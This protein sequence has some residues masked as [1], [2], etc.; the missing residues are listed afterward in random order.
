MHIFK[1]RISFLFALVFTNFV[2]VSEAALSSSESLKPVNIQTSQQSEEESQSLIVDYWSGSYPNIDLTNIQIAGVELEPKMSEEFSGTTAL[3]ILMDTSNPARQ[4][5]VAQNIKDSGL[6]KQNGK[7]TQSIA[8]A[9]FDK[10]LSVVADFETDDEAWNEALDAVNAKGMTTELWRNVLEG[11]NI[12]DKQQAERKALII[13]T[14]GKAEDTAYSLDEVVKRARE[15]NI[16]V[17]GIG[18]PGKV[19]E[20]VFLQGLR[21]VS[22]ETGGLFTEVASQSSLTEEKAEQIVSAINSG[23]RAIFDLQALEAENYNANQAATYNF[24]TSA[25]GENFT[26]SEDIDLSAFAAPDR[27]Q[28][29]YAEKAPEPLRPF[30]NSSTVL[31]GAIL[32]GLLMV[33]IFLLMLK[34]QREEQGQSGTAGGKPIAYLRVMDSSDQPIS[35]TEKATRLGRNKDNDVVL[36]NDSVSGFHAEIHLRREGHLVIT[37]MNSMNGTLLN[38]EKIQSAEVSANDVISVGEVKLM[39]LKA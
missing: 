3:L 32:L 28:Q 37:D 20:T 22:D 31:V 27:I 13:M 25:E 10:E 36:D 15:A 35:I 1:L 26:F 21:R 18:Y 16:P 7:D 6:F 38:G 2:L 29:K 14:D 33:A 34:R 24:E 9:T 23:G 12:L 8:L 4:E 5:I 11:L 39:L 19:S 30:I 17:Y